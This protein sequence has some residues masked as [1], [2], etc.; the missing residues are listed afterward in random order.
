MDTDAGL[1]DV[2]VSSQYEILAESNG[3]AEHS[4]P[5]RASVETEDTI[6]KR[7]RSRSRER[8]ADRSGTKKKKQEKLSRSRSPR[9]LNGS[10][11]DNPSVS[12]SMTPHT[13]DIFGNDLPSNA[14]GG[15]NALQLKR[16]F[17]NYRKPCLAD[18]SE[19]LMDL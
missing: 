16:A 4:D 17:Q 13:G 18:V 12:G 5:P 8:D 6:K 9:S 2:T 11:N 19:S 15:G 14:A 7:R 1:A 3:V 10:R